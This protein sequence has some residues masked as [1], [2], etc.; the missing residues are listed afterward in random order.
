MI[1]GNETPTTG[2]I[3]VSSRPSLLSVSAALQ[4]QL[5]GAE[6]VRLG[7]LAKGLSPVEVDELAD[8]VA[9]WADI[10]DAINRPLHTYSSGM[11]ARLKFSIATAVKP[12][13]LLLD[14]AL[15]TGD[16]TFNDRA[17]ERMEGFL[18]GAST[19]FLVSHS[20]AAIRKQCTRAIWLHDGSLI[21]D[22]NASEAVKWYVKWS[23][24]VVDGKDEEAEHIIR[25]LAWTH[26]KSRIV[27]N[28]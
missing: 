5:T 3:F 22:L 1:A 18:D 24:A 23:R 21:A 11:G 16:A 2:E 8:S 12:E 9:E 20:A 19:V 26:E 15:A 14:E 27:F 6:N 28:R 4:P 7:L 13:I 10:G 17:Q 25:S